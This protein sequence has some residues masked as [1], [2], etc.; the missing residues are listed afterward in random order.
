M[1]HFV[2]DNRKNFQRPGYGQSFICVLG[3]TR[4]LLYVYMLEIIQLMCRV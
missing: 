1:V 2:V 3:I 4:G